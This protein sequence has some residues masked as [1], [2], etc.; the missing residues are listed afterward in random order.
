MRRFT[1]LWGKVYHDKTG[2]VRNM[3]IP[4]VVSLHVVGMVFARF[5]AKKDFKFVLG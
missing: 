5:N 1:S 3:F 2:S 4:H